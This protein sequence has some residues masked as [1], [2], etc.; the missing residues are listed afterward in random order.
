MWDTLASVGEWRRPR[1]HSLR[2][3]WTFTA[4]WTHL[5]VSY[6]QEGPHQSSL[7]ETNLI[8]GRRAGQLKCSTTSSVNQFRGPLGPCELCGTRPVLRRT[9]SIYLI[10]W[11]QLFSTLIHMFS[12]ALFHSA[13]LIGLHH[14]TAQHS[15]A[16]C[17]CVC[18][19]LQACISRFDAM[20]FSVVKILL[21]LIRQLLLLLDH[22]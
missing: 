11:D 5:D 13:T 12:S 15:T 14:S 18:S 22:E 17:V 4:V 19:F 3:A 1:S 9:V 8:K 7:L 16:Q 10:P 6:L 21:Y 20:L 2:S